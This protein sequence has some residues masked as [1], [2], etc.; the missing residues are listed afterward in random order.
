MTIGQRNQR[1][2][3]LSEASQTGGMTLQGNFFPKEKGPFSKNKK[4]TSLLIAKLGGCAPSAPCSKILSY[5]N[6]LITRVSQH[7]ITWAVERIYGRWVKTKYEP[8]AKQCERD[9]ED[10]PI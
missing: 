6:I 8:L 4:G 1:P 3:I 9:A 7:S 2:C 10:V 5:S